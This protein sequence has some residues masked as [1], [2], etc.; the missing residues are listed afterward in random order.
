M[1]IKFLIIYTTNQCKKDDVLTI[2]KTSWCKGK[3]NLS[4]DFCFFGSFGKSLRKLEFKTVT[5]QQQN[6]PF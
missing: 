2:W 6:L 5:I 1:S 4:Q 3:T